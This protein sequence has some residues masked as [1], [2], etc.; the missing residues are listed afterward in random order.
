MQ[1]SPA[2]P[3]FAGFY[4]SSLAAAFPN[5]WIGDTAN[6]ARQTTLLISPFR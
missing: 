6:Q 4:G 5:L 2:T 1:T 3:P